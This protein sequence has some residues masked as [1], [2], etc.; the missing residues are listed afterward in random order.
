MNCHHNPLV[1]TITAVVIVGI[2]SSIV[3]GESNPP[4]ESEDKRIHDN[5]FNFDIRVMCGPNCLWQIAHVHGKEYSLEMIE[6][7]AQTDP[8]KGTTIKCMI[9]AAKQMGFEVEG[10]KTNIKAIARDPR[11][12]I[13][14]LNLRETTH[15]VILD[16]VGVKEVR[17]LDGVKFRNL[18]FSELESVWDGYAI[19]FGHHEGCQT[20]GL[21]C[22]L[23]R[24]L[25][26]SGF[27]ISLL[28]SIFGIKLTC[29]YLS[30]LKQ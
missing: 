16:K 3:S 22:Y 29:S 2:A 21:Q 28:V 20:D 26:I 7:L 8:Q 19:L 23:G 11:I 6:T 4:Q 12:A 13:L 1:F 15:Y 24:G 27:L 14:L 5:F 25:Q 17:L 30:R 10:V 9:G 18:S